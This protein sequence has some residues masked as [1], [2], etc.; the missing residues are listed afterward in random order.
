MAEQIRYVLICDMCSEE[1]LCEDDSYALPSDWVAV[2][3]TTDQR[4]FVSAILCNACSR[5][6]HIRTIISRMQLTNQQP[7]RYVE[8]Y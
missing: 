5:E 3:I 1:A 7:G 8:P 2:T 6:H 4:E